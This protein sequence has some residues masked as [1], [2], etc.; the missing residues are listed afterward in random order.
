M[1]WRRRH[2]R[3][4]RSNCDLES[5]GTTYKCA[6]AGGTTT[7][8]LLSVVAFA[9]GVL[10]LMYGAADALT[11]SCGEGIADTT[12]VVFASATD[13][14]NIVAIGGSVSLSPQGSESGTATATVTGAF[15]G[16]GQP[17]TFT[18]GLTELGTPTEQVSDI[19]TL[20]KTATGS[21][22]HF[23]RTPKV[24]LAVVRS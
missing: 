7:K 1:T 13:F 23:N 2:E 20:A 21:R 8:R 22:F 15:L 17:T 5:W 24:L 4:R 16:A 6:P 11:I 19:I 14:S 3:S 10:A 18:L 9:A 12:D